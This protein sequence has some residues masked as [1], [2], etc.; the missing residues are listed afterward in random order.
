MHLCR[1]RTS[2]VVIYPL[3]PKGVEHIDRIQCSRYRSIR[4]INPLMPKGV[5]HR[6]AI[7]CIQSTCSVIY[8]LMPK[9]V[10]HTRKSDY[11]MRLPQ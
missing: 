4:V 9:G 7:A 3:M 10:E 6:F 11:A 5:E 1:H 2:S 8:P